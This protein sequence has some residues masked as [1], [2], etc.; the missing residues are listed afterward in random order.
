MVTSSASGTR[1]DEVAS[2]I[3]RIST[4][5]PPTAMPG[6]FTF[7]QYLVADEEPL[8]FHTGPRRMFPL[9]REAVAAVTPVEG[10][11]WVSFSH[12]EADECGSLNEWLA[13]AP[14]AEPLCGSIAAMVSVGD[15]ADRP[16]RAMADGESLRIGRHEVTWADV[17]HLPHGWECGY[18]FERTTGTLLCGD[19]LT[20]PGCAEGPAVTR[21]DILSPSEALRSG[22]DYFSATRNVT[23]LI[24]KLAAFRPS[25]LA[26][27][28]GYAWEGDGAAMLRALGDRLASAGRTA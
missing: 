3:Y 12:Y 8:L 24:E 9:V 19:L 15:V 14:R 20:Q 11:R 21:G 25:V 17:P 1:V 27:M 10:L 7:N 6:G 4:P 2:G 26:C 16:P 5:I 23:T 22:L 28:H 18:L 13:V